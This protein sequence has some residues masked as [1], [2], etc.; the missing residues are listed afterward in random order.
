M[1]ERNWRSE[2][3]IIEINMLAKTL[4]NPDL[5]S[6]FF[7]NYFV[8]WILKRDA[9]LEPECK[10]RFYIRFG[11]NRNGAIVHLH[12]LSGQAQADS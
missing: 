8:L 2:L 3:M 11:F 10:N 12:D 5:N 7:F 9:D 4:F 6:G 1:N